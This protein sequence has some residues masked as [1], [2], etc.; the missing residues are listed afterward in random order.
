VQD[1]VQFIDFINTLRLMHITIY[2][3]Q[4]LTVLFFFLYYLYC[5]SIFQRT[6]CFRFKSG[7]KGKRFYFNY[8]MFSEVF[9]RF[10]FSIVSQTLLA[11]GKEGKEEKQ[12]TF[13]LRIGLQR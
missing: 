2:I 6:C 4:V 11:K 5:L 1:A 13:S 10:S 12:N 7:C 9:F 3:R 8:Q